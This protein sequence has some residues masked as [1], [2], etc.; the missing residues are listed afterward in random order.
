[1]LADPATPA[2]AGLPRRLRRR[3]RQGARAP[4]A[5]RGHAGAPE[6]GHRQRPRR[7]AAPATRR[8]QD[9]TVKFINDKTS[10]VALWGVKAAR[11]M[12]P[13]ALGL[14]NDNNPLL[15]A[16]VQAV[17]R[18]G[19]GPIVTEI[20][21]ALSLHIFTANPK[22]PPNVIKGAVPEMLRVF[23][24]RVDGYAGGVPPDPAIDNDASE[25]L[26]FSLVW[27][28]LTPQQRTE[29]VQ[30]MAD[31]LSFAAQHAAVH[32]GQRPPG[33]DARLQADRRGPAG[34]RRRAEE[35]G[36]FQRR[37]GSHTD[38]HRDGRRRRSSKRDRAVGRALQKAVPG[39]KPSP[40]LPAPPA[41]RRRPARRRPARQR[42]QG[43]AAGGRRQGRRPRRP[44]QVRR[45]GRRTRQRPDRRR[46]QP[47]CRRSPEAPA[48]RAPAPAPRPRPHRP[49]R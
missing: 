13:T 34:D 42:R 38:Q 18:L 27:Q 2:L 32:G 10:A 35:P 31:L 29:A 20:Y 3:R 21:D 19:F 49:P 37:Q 23:R 16:L 12:L 8:L 40:K 25:F 6:R 43:A 11:A 9:I 14:G 44:A 39:V 1:M 46:R 28:Q 36:R 4:H 26:S 17:Q 33:A 47:P 30:A 45:P 24:V 22:P 15:V 5:A 7:R 41:G 48:R